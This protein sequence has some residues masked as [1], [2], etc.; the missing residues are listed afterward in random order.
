MV[1]ADGAGRE[2]T[3]WLMIAAEAREFEGILKRARE[4]RPISWPGA[5]FSREAEGKNARWILVANGP[6][7]RLVERTLEAL[8]SSR[9]GGDRA[10]QIRPEPIGEEAQEAV[11]ALV[12][13]GA[14]EPGDL[15]VGL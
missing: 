2:M 4:I 7:P 9:S 15:L 1:I 12:V 10:G 14:G 5:E 8:A 6:G 3:T 11:R 13:A